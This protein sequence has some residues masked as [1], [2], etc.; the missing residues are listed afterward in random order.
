MQTI[1]FFKRLLVMTYDGLLLTSVVFF[2]SAVLM[3]FFTWLGPDAFFAT[4]DPANPNLIERSDLGR[5]IGGILVTINVFCV[6]FFFYG[7]FWT[8][9]G[10]TLGMKAWKLYLVKPDGK[11]I[12][13]NTAFKRYLASLLSWACLGLGFT[14]ALLDARKRTW[15]DILTNTMIVKSAE[16]AAKDR[17]NNLK[18]HQA[19]NRAKGK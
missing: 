13:W 8:H 10:Q 1:G 9:G 17:S 6:S 11:F 5:L 16:Q 18:R 3:G 4:P 15:H 2:S 19:K 7:W 12:D 14:W